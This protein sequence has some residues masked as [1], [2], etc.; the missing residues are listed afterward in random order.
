MFSLIR[1]A[2]L[3]ML[4]F[5]AG[6]LMERSAA[7]TRCAEAGGTMSAGLCKGTS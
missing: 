1:T 2:L 3:V 7:G 4:A 6:V 5:V